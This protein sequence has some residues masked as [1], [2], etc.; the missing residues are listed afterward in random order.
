MTEV[1]RYLMVSNGNVTGLVD[2]LVADGLV[3]RVANARDRRA[4]LALLT[5]KGMR[6]FTA[7]ADVHARWLEEMLAG[8]DRGRSETLVGLLD[9]LRSATRAGGSA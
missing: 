4:T 5:Q 1:S 6:R 2:R 9:E 7:M 3:V 8:F